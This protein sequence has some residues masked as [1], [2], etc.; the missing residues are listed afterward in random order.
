[1][2]YSFVNWVVTY[3]II[4]TRDTHGKVVFAALFGGTLV[5][6]QLLVKFWHI[7]IF[8]KVNARCNV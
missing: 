1:M 4:A 6:G 2:T 8:P 3:S 5:K 7:K